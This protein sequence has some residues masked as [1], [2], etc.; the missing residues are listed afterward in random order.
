M[1][2][3]LTSWSLPACTL[4]E[5][6][7]LAKVLGIGALDLGY[8]YRSAL[9]KADLLADPDRQADRVAALG[10]DLPNLYHL[11]GNSLADRNLADPAHRDR[12]EHDLRQ[13]VRFC[14]RAGIGRCSS[15]RACATPARAGARPWSNRPRACADSCR[16]PP[17]RA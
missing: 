6:A 16:S 5:A 1:R 11:F 9:P 10:V 13:A 12:N 17:R 2:L 8:F 3:S 7:G 15:C 4:D 14:R